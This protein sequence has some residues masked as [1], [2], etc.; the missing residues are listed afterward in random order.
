VS[1][2]TLWA[3]PLTPAAFAPYGDVIDADAAQRRYPIN[4]GSAWRHDAL[5]LTDV[6]DA[7]GHGVVAIVRAQPASLPVRLRALERHRLGSQLIM[8]LQRARFLVVVAPAQSTRPFDEARCF[9]A[10]PG[11]GVQYRRGTWHHPLLALDAPTD[12]LALD[13][14]AHDGSPDDDVQAWPDAPWADVAR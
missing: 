6:H 12:F 2:P 4:E 9:V 7:G 14:R 10:A 13:R 8:P 3:Q 1:A 5:A 11:Q